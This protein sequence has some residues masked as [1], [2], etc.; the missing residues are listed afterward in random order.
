MK[1]SIFLILFGFFITNAAFSPYLFYFTDWMGSAVY[2]YELAVFT[3][4]TTRELM[5]LPLRG[6]AEASSG[7]TSADLVRFSYIDK[8]V[9]P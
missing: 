6:D 2:G 3:L 9:L 8:I 5:C 4:D 7:T 1:P